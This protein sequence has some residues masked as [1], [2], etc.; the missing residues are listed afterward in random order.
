MCICD[1]YKSKESQMNKLFLFISIIYLNNLYA[2]NIDFNKMK[3]I[4]EARQSSLD[5]M[6]DYPIQD[7]QSLYTLNID[8][9]KISFWWI[10][11]KKQTGTII[12]VHGFM[13]NKSHMLN[14]ANMYYAMGRSVILIDLRA[15]G[16]SEGEKTTSGP[17][18][19]EDIL[20]VISYYTKNLNEYG[21]LIIHGYSHGGR[22]AVFAAEENYNNIEAIILES[23]PY[24]LEESFK[25]TFKISEVPSMNA[26]NI[27]SALDKISKLPILLL[28]GND[29]TA[30]IK[31]E[32]NLIASK[33]KNSNSSLI[34]FDGAGHDLTMKE[35]EKLYKESIS[36][37]INKILK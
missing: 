25:R 9:L 23:I 37:F 33:F 11:N 21:K 36:K 8:S 19:N 17:E 1:F 18:I 35:T 7:Y 3:D 29:D 30:I 22:A 15:R 16:E 2:Q 10:P 12:L 6:I 27:D 5:K 20:A 13:M 32:A 24:S 31:S 28:F 26:G 14:R 34:E 4:Y